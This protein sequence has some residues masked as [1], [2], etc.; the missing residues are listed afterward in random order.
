MI[1]LAWGFRV[2]QN[3]GHPGQR[4]KDWELR[5]NP[6]QITGMPTSRPESNGPF[7]CSLNPPTPPPPTSPDSI[8][9][10]SPH[11]T[12]QHCVCSKWGLLYCMNLRTA[13]WGSAHLNNTTIP[14]QPPTPPGWTRSDVTYVKLVLPEERSEKVSGQKAGCHIGG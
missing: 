10:L 13:A 9:H 7:G 4:A 8:L 3:G 6:F 12:Q 5:K 2:K 1:P 11:Q 14:I